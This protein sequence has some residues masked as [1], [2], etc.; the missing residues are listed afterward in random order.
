M[1]KIRSM[2]RKFG[3]A[4]EVFEAKIDRM[5]CCLKEMCV[6]Q[7]T[8]EEKK[9]FEDEID[10]LR[11]LPPQNS[12]IVEYIGFQK[13]P[14]K[15]QLF[16]GMYNGSILDLITMNMKKERKFSVKQICSMCEQIL[17]GIIILHGRNVLHRDLKCSNIFYEG[18]CKKFDTLYF[19]LGD[20]GDSKILTDSK[21]A[22]MRKGTPSWKAPE[23]YECDGDKNYSYPSDMWS[24]GMVMYEMMTLTFPYCGD[25]FPASSIVNGKLPVIRQE[26][27]VLYNVIIPLWESIV[28]RSPEK[29][30]KPHDALRTVTMMIEEIVK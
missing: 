7:V 29:R 19:V 6:D 22:T 14:D 28:E 25:N 10:I 1:K 3:T 11:S 2:Y 26:D 20:F 24:F 4:V 15:I 21:T 12:H 17:M 27:R 18:D 13:T 5:S 16:M 23:V 8:A 30:C 9:E